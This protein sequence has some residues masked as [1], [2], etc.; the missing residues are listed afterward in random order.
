MTPGSLSPGPCQPIQ[1]SSGCPPTHTLKGA[2]CDP[3]SH[4]P[5]LHTP[6]P[7]ADP[8]WSQSMLIPPLHWT[9]PIKPLSVLSHWWHTFSVSSG[10]HMFLPRNL[11]KSPWTA[12]SRVT[13]HKAL[14]SPQKR[15]SECKRMHYFW[16][17]S[18]QYVS[19]AFTYAWAWIPPTHPFHF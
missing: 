15:L 5:T 6:S 16:Q 2:C 19:K 1:R 7:A 3:S 12:E 11:A 14:C 10:F 8:L 17:D 9:S 18:W 13:S 4:F